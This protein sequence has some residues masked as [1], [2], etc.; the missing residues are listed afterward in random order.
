M[1]LL[2]QHDSAGIHRSTVQ[3]PPWD[4][5]GTIFGQIRKLISRRLGLDL[6]SIWL[7]EAGFYSNL[8]TAT[9]CRRPYKNTIF[10]I[11]IQNHEKQGVANLVPEWGCK[12]CDRF[13]A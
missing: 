11:I 3:G 7:L 4:H 5:L 13:H 10:K 8:Y 2:E 1:F 6:G 9:K 12:P